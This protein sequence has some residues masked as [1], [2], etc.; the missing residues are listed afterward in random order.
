MKCDKG[1]MLLYAV[2]DR[3]WTGRQSLYEQVESA[4]KG[5]V[6]CVQLREKD[7]DDDSFTAEAIEIGAL[8]KSYGVPFI[9][10]DNVEV[11]IRSGADGVH[12]GQDDLSA[13]SVR[14]RA[15]ENMI[16]GVSAHSV[17]EALEAV[18]NGADYLG[19]GSMFATSTKANVVH[20]KPE[21]LRDICAA[22]EVPVVAIGGIGKGNILS[23]K[24]TGA[25]GVALVSAIF[26]AED[27]E[28]ECR[29]LKSLSEEMVKS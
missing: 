1:A 21:T 7:M 24:G 4:L 3:S 18:R 8:C 28:S 16:I 2:T 20:L 22:V 14:A 10:N 11:A 13:A 17:E 5:G 12:V 23:L 29:L 15:G 19:V 9:I 26:S 6:T 25:D 27:I